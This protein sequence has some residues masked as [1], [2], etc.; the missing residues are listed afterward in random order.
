MSPAGCLGRVEN[1]KVSTGEIWNRFDREHLLDS[2]GR[3]L[4]SMVEYGCTV[5]H[6]HVVRLPVL[7]EASYVAISCLQYM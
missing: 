6:G 3:N 4:D 2:Y 7:P 1:S 5:L